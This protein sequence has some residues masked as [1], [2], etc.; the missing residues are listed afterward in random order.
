MPVINV[1]DVPQAT[2][3]VLRLR[4]AANG[5]S[6]QGLVLSLLIDSAATLTPRE[7]AIQARGIAAHSHVTVRDVVQAHGSP[8]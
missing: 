6:V 8:S 3:D 4:A 5:Q 7:A 2:L 1:R